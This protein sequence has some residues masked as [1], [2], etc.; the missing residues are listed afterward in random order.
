MGTEQVNKRIEAIE[1]LQTEIKNAKEILNG[2]LENEDEYRQVTEEANEINSKKK[3]LKDEILN[4][5][6]NQKLVQEIKEN[7][8]FKS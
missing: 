6:S 5:G 2:E 3:R 1:K 7:T 4:K 8:E